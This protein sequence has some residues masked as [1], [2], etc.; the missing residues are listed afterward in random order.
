VFP[1]NSAK[2]KEEN[3]L[4]RPAQIAHDIVDTSPGHEFAPGTWWNVFNACTFSIDHLLGHSDNNR[5]YSAWYG[6]GRKKK[7]AALEHAVEYAKAS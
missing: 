2:K 7:L 1:T 4:S 3:V 6:N 5:L